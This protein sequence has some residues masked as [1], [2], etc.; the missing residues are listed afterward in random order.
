M[1][2]FSAHTR[3]ISGAAALFRQVLALNPDHSGATLQLAKALDQGGKPEEALPGAMAEFIAYYNQRRYHEGLGNVAPADVYYGRR[4]QIQR[5]GEEQKELTIQARLRC[6][7]GR[8]E[9]Q[10]EGDSNLKTVAAA[11]SS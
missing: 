6:N 1:H 2:D 5:S 9:P 10:P 8:R 4:E 11:S 7:L 3:F